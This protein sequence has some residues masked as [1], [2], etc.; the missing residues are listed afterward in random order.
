M[1]IVAYFIDTEDA[2]EYYTFRLI[3]LDSMSVARFANPIDSLLFWRKRIIAASTIVS[4]LI[5]LQP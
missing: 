5:E 3:S 2:R 1:F 4:D